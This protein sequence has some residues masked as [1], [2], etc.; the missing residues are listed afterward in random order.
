VIDLMP[1]RR[2]CCSGGPRCCRG[3]YLR[4]GWPRNVQ[5]DGS[6]PVFGGEPL[7][8]HLRAAMELVER[9]WDDALFA[10]LAGTGA[11]DG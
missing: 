10:L 8:T 9:E 3:T 1:G 5:F 4:Y 7:A 6:C 2:G 11:R